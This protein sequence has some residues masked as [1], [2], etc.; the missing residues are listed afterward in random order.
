MP[1]ISKKKFSFRQKCEEWHNRK[2]FNVKIEI[3][4]SK[5]DMGRIAAKEG[6]YALRAEL[7]L[8][9]SANII[10]ATGASQFEMLAALSVEPNIDWSKVSIFHLDEYVGMSEAQPASFRRYLRERFVSKLP[11]PPGAFH[12][13][14]AEKDPEGECRRLNALIGEVSI[15]VAFVGIGENAHLAFNFEIGIAFAQDLQH[16]AHLARGRVVVAAEIRMR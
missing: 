6:G 9:G 3:C 15:C 8:E 4:A 1:Y 7:K 14:D 10:V 11:T 5:T 12:A 2:E 13:I 16:A